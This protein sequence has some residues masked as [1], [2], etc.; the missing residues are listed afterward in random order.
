MMPD[1]IISFVFS[2]QLSLISRTTPLQRKLARATES[3][4]DASNRFGIQI[5]SANRPRG[6]ESNLLS[7]QQAHLR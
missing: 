7:L 4:Q 5:R 3:I 2:E 1:I 6:T